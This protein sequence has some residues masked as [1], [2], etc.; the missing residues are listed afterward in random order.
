MAVTIQQAAANAFATWLQSKLP[1]VPVEPRWPAADKQKPEKSITVVAAGRRRD[2]P[3]DLRLLK[4]TNVGN[5]QTRAVW[6][7]AACIQPFQLDVWATKDVVRDDILA[8]LDQF[9]H[10]GQASLLTSLAATPAGFGTPLVLG[11]GWEDSIADFDFSEPDL[12]NTSDTVNRSLYR[13]TF[14]GNAYFMLTVSSLTAR[15]TVINFQL[16]LQE[17]DGTLTDA[18]VPPIT[19]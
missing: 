1:D 15:Q 3:I 10:Q 5:T 19:S 17:T 4:K 14:R 2:T 18:S 7:V 8:R 12:E 13:A 9:L 11:D 16:R 6:Q